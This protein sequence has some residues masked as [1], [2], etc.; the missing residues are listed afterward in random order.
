MNNMNT[1]LRLLSN[2]IKCKLNFKQKILFKVSQLIVIGD[3]ELKIN[4]LRQLIFNFYHFDF[5]VNYFKIYFKV[6]ILNLVINNAKNITEK[7]YIIFLE[8]N[9]PLPRALY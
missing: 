8:S 3:N 5:K 7:K 6:E 9:K 4:Y 2:N 1:K